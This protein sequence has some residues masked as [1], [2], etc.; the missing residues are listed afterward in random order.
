[1]NSNTLRSAAPVHS[2]S[3]PATTSIGQK[4]TPAELQQGKLFINQSRDGVIGATRGLGD[5]QFNFKPAPDRWSIAENLEHMVMV[6]EIILGRVCEQL[7]DA[8]PPPADRDSQL[9][10]TIIVSQL[11]VRLVKF[12]GPPFL[13]P[14]GQWTPSVSLDRLASNCARLDEYLESTPGLREHLL[15][16]PPLKAITN[17][18]HTM[19]DGYQWVLAS[20]AHNERHTKQILEV[21]ADPNFPAN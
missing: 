13:Q 21:K 3:G 4:L 8:P 2:G 18:A 12:P 16:S 9:I 5:K 6:Q 20:A 7:A 14:S 1:V 10:D 11:P 15:E 17:G 19:M